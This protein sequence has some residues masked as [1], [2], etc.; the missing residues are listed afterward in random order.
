[1]EKK[2]AQTWLSCKFLMVKSIFYIFIFALVLAACSNLKTYPNDLTKNVF[3]KTKIESG[4]KVRVDIFEVNKK[5][6]GEYIGSVELNGSSRK[7]GLNSSKLHYL[8]F[9]FISSGFF[10]A[11]TSSSG[12][13]TLVKTRK[14]Y[15]YD[16]LLSYEDSIYDV[17]I[18]E[19]RINRKK[20]NEL[21]IIPLQDCSRIK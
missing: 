12:L 17:E 14:G 3:V 19:K 10:T 8:D 16:V 21:E 7:I 4:I 20:G 15:I 18:G 1:M 13:S 2:V 6:E 5:C 11:S 9:R